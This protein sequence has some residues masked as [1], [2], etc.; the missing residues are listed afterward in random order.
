MQRNNINQQSNNTNS[1]IEEE[2]NFQQLQDSLKLD[3]NLLKLYLIELFNHLSLRNPK[4]KINS[5]SAFVITTETFSSYMKIPIPISEKLF[6]SFLEKNKTSLTREAFLSGMMLLYS[7][8]YEETLKLIFDVYDFKK[9]GSIDKSDVKLLLSYIPFHNSFHGNS[10]FSY[11]QEAIA[12]LDKLLKATFTNTNSI[13]FNEYKRVVE[14]MHSDIFLFLL[15]FFYHSIPFSY[16]SVELFGTFKVTGDSDSVKNSYNKTHIKTG[17]C[18]EFNDTIINNNNSNNNSNNQLNSIHGNCSPPNVYSPIKKPGNFNKYLASSS[19]FEFSNA[20]STDGNSH[21]NVNNDEEISNKVLLGDISE[22]KQFL[23]KVSPISSYHNNNSNSISNQQVNDKKQSIL[24]GG[25][26][27]TVQ[28]DKKPSTIKNMNSEIRKVSTQGNKNVNVNTNNNINL[29]NTQS[30]FTYKNNKTS[31]NS[32]NNNNINTK[33]DSFTKSKSHAELKTTTEFEVYITDLTNSS[34]IKNPRLKKS[35]IKINDIDIFFFKDNTKS[36]LLFLVNLSNYCVGDIESL[37]INKLNYYHIPLYLINNSTLIS[38]KEENISSPQK[39]R[40]SNTNVNNNNTYITNINN[41]SLLLTS[42]DQVNI[43]YLLLKN[44]TNQQK[45]TDVYNIKDLLGE[46]AFGQVKL[47]QKKSTKEQ[48]AIKIL[49]KD[50][51]SK[52]QLFMVRNEIDIMALCCHPNIGRLE[53][54][55]EDHKA[56]YIVMEYLKGIDLFSYLDE[57]MCLSENFIK[58]IIKRVVDIVKYLH[59]FGIVHRDL[60]LDNLMIDTKADISSNGINGSDISNSNLN[61]SN[62]ATTKTIINNTNKVIDDEKIIPKIRTKIDR[63]S[64]KTLSVISSSLNSMSFE[65]K[66]FNKVSIKLTDFGISKVIGLDE[67][68]TEPI[69]TLR[70]SA[71]EIL[72]NK[73]YN[74]QVDIWSLGVCMYLLYCGEYPFEDEERE[75]TIQRI[76]YEECKFKQAIWKNASTHFRDLVSGCLNKDP[77]KRYN[78]SKVSKHEFLK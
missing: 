21:D 17:S 70:F 42:K 55:I 66:D 53:E 73:P 78:I 69:G 34:N 47:A 22:L 33:S 39:Q 46:G 11:Q 58:F 31:I 12:E 74:K 38:P 35:Y 13:S 32:N 65:E 61:I 40:T 41:V 29:N 16:K 20:D 37:F 45:I 56:I 10:K 18:F 51:L 23:P 71:P 48:F 54:I 6:N 15:T 3:K 76:L 27:L 57:K 68:L 24:K 72:S 63:E 75:T 5:S 49:N 25:K 44:K 7:G 67:Y 64:K 59:S 52:E 50:K 77:N 26:T 9:K 36:S 28:I 43:F 19:F 2:L 1:N 14:S 8:E 30:A 60:K 4:E 62:T